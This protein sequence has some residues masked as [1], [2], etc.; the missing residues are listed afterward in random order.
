MKQNL[1]R[2]L[3]GTGSQ[4][5]RVAL[6][7]AMAV[8][9]AVTVAACG[10][11][12]T[13]PATGVEIRPLSADFGTRKAIN[14]SP[15][16]TSIDSSGLDAEVIPS[17]NIKQDLDLLMAAGYR[18]IRIFSS[19]DKVAR[20][21]LEVIRANNMDMRVQL[22]IFVGGD[23]NRTPAERAAVYARD[24]AE[25]ARGIALANEYRSIVVAVSVGNETQVDFSGIRTDVDTLVRYLRRVRGA[26]TQPVTTDDNFAAWAGFPNAIIDEVDYASIHAYPLLDTIFSPNLW[27]WRQRNVPEAQRAAAMM[28]ASITEAKRQYAEVRRTLNNK[29]LTNMPIIVGETGWNAV[30]LGRLA[31]RAHPV[32]QKMYVDRLAAWA[33]EGRSGNGPLNIFLFQGFDEPWKQGDDAWGLFDKDRRARYAVQSLGTCG[34]TWT[35]APGSFTAASALYFQPAVVNTAV[36]QSRYTIYSDAPIGT[37]ELRPTGLR[38]D[39]FDGNSVNAP[40]T[41][42][43]AAPGDGTSSIALTPQP[44]N[45]GWGFLNQSAT[46]PATSANLSGFS[47]GTLRFSVRTQY[48]G[49]IEIGIATDT[50]DRDVQEAYLQIGNGEF[51]Y[52]N[53]GVWCAVSIP[54]A[55]FQR[56]NPKIDL[57]LVLTRFIIADRYSFTGKPL[58]ANI[59]TPIGLDAI[60]WQR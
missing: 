46:T 37:S 52:C 26:I 35:C 57:S 17:A 16:R 14:Y 22:G 5:A 40:E 8:V 24:D 20:Q 30:D 15:F 33:A 21:T 39:A 25:I 7:G 36:A 42:A 1:F 6:A 12:G 49:K 31:F 4:G 3:C 41:T 2:T 47:G 38:F 51:G 32:N 10:G 48:P 58:N 56:V 50:A 9:L 59:T 11:S 13:T 23:S 19:S 27:D 29:G 55:E 53:T 28:D 54:L 43:T 18:L 45:F 60:Y 44:K 34:T